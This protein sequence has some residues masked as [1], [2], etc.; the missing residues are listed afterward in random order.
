MDDETE[1]PK[2]NAVLLILWAVP[3]LMSLVFVCV[4]LLLGKGLEIALASA[5]ASFLY[6]VLRYGM[7]TQDSPP[8]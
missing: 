5:L 4:T 1:K 7:Y 8:Q 3:L 2:P 6:F